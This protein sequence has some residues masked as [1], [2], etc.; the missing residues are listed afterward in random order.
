VITPSWS[1][2]RRELRTFAAICLPGFGLVGFVLGQA[3]G[4]AHAAYAAWGLALLVPPL[5]FAFPR[6]VRPLYVAM[7]ALAL[8]IGWLLSEILVRAIYYGV[9]TPIA[10]VFRLAGRDALQRKRPQVDSY[11]RTYESPREVSDAFRQG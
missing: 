9:L 10:L 7:L 6:A 3:A 1:P 5:G 11:W 2:S 8:P 4:L